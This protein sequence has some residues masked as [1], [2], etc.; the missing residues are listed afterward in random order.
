MDKIHRYKQYELLHLSLLCSK[1]LYSR[2]LISN[3]VETGLR[4]EHKKCQV[5]RGARKH[6]F[7][8]LHYY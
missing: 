6:P 2:T 1:Q 5:I 4:S 8:I 7:K 3:P